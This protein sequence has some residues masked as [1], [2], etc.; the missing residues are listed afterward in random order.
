M[1]LIS[2]RPRLAG[3]VILTAITA[4]CTEKLDN[5]AGCPILC[6][7]PGGQIETVTI[8][9]VSL[10]TTVSALVGQGTERFLLLATRGDTL[11]AR[12][13]I[14]FDSIPARFVRPGADTTSF[15]VTTA[16]SAFLRVRVDTTGAKLPGPLTLDLYDVY[17][18]APDS[19]VAEIAALFTPERLITS[20][21]FEIAALKD[22]LNIPIPGDAIVARAGGPLRIGIRARGPQSV[23]VRLLSEEGAGTPSVLSYRVSPDTTI[24]KVTLFP[25]SKTPEN[26]PILA[27]SLADYTLLVK[28]T[29][30]GPL[31]LLN[32]G[33]LPPTRVYMRFNVPS[34]L[35]DSVDVVR[36]TLLLTQ[37]PNT[38]ID[39]NDTLLVLPLVSLA[40]V[41]VTDIAK[42]TQI[43]AIAN[44]DTLHVTP[45]SS[46]LKSVEVANIIALWRVQ[47]AEETPRAIVLL[48]TQEGASPLEARFYSAEAAPELRPRLRI[49]YSARKS[50]G[51]P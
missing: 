40:G 14:R 27:S 47:K 50:T 9:A 41:A 3:L 39:P 35:I 51:L 31:T 32:V 49:S 1:K 13:V 4:A 21:T 37:V 23:Q 6:P 22:T 15:P 24:A 19:A 26:Q 2:V 44:A 7:G 25:Y 10:D 28:G 5:S 12:A 17:S 16:D 33:G 11:D 42:A 20:A 29:T 8:D 34:L 18:T 36:A 46:G 45:G 30:P 48:T 43:T 38:T